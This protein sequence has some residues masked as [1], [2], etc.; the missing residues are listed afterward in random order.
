[1]NYGNKHPVM[2]FQYALTPYRSRLKP[3]LSLPATTLLFLIIHI[4]AVLAQPAPPPEPNILF[5]ILDSARADHFSAY[6][7]TLETTPRMQAISRKG[8]LFLNEFSQGADTFQSVPRYLASRYVSRALFQ[9]DAWISGMRQATPDDIALRDDDQLIYLPQFLARQGYRT[10]LFTDHYAF[11]E[12]TDLARQFHEFRHFPRPRALNDARVFSQA[13]DWLRENGQKKFFLYVHVMAPHGGYPEKDTDAEFTA[14]FD[15]GLIAEVR[16][17]AANPI[18]K[19]WSQQELRVLRALYDS[20]LKHADRWVGELYSAL[21][22]LKL[23]KNTIFMITA[24]HGKNMGEHGIIENAG[25]PWD[26]VLHVPLILVYPP[27]IPPATKVSGLTEGV[28]IFPTFLDLAG[29][30]IPSDKAL[31]GVSLAPLIS[32]PDAG[33]KQVFSENFIRTKDYKYMVNENF[34]FD[35]K[36]DPREENNLAQSRTRLTKSLRSLHQR[37]M[38]PHLTRYNAAKAVSL[39]EEP[40]FIP[41]RHFNLTPPNSAERSMVLTEPAALLSSGTATRPWLLDVYGLTP[42]L[43]RHPTVSS[44]P[45]VAFSCPLPDGEYSI[46]VLLNSFSSNL[47]SISQ[48]GLTF[49][50]SQQEPY[51]TPLNLKPSKQKYDRHTGE[52]QNLAYLELGRTTVRNRTFRL[53]LAIPSPPEIR[54]SLWHIRFYPGIADKPTTEPSEQKKRQ[55][56]ETMRSTGYWKPLP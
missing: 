40:F 45:A 10:A 46:S 36:A 4:S 37:L 47:P 11:T 53:E 9:P 54:Y 44:A 21:E 49:R 28:D 14:Q 24:D 2:T 39:P 19:T 26:S 55:I 1:M 15:A 13:I 43:M 42:G 56:E 23:D 3:A 29:I 7:Y 52:L 12:E 20:S 5:I 27:R 30:A 33:K 16:K 35:L 51:R 8:T 38:K 17:K 6:G 25:P 18:T 41:L 34:L 48:L 50:F 22:E 32:Q 31:A